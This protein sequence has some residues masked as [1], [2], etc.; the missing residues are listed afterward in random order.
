MEPDLSVGSGSVALTKPQQ[1]F[2]EEHQ[3]R[4]PDGS[5]FLGVICV[6]AAPPAGQNIHS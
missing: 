5:D 2:G 3:Q 6:F 1:V 4:H